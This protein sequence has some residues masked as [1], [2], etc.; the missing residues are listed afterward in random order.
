[1]AMCVA[2][3]DAVARDEWPRMARTHGTGQRRTRDAGNQLAH[4]A[5][6]HVG[7]VLVAGTLGLALPATGEAAGPWQ[8]QVI[9]AETGQPLPEVAVIGLWHRRAPGHPPLF[10]GRTGFGRLDRDDDGPGG[11]LHAAGPELR[12]H[13]HRDPGDRR[14]RARAIPSAG[15]GGWRNP[16]RRAGADSPGPDAVI[17]MRPLP[18][19]EARRA[20]LEGTWPR[21]ERERLR[22]GAGEHAA[23]P[24]DWLDLPV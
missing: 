1:M 10:L 21:A 17:E 23:T 9:D 14:P 8:A 18:T 7:T 13:R 11:P 15:Y 3:I 5:R 20:Y 12:P 24:A 16:G 6:A 19:P 4:V 2:R 22:R